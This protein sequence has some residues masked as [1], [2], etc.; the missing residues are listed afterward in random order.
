MTSHIKAIIFDF[1][2]VLVEWEPRHIFRNY[3]P[4]NAAIEAFLQEI[5]FKQW[6]VEQDKGRSFTEGIELL[7]QKFPQHTGIF[8]AFQERW[9]ESIV[10]EIEGTVQLL[11]ELKAKGHPVYGLSN[12]SAE[13]FPIARARYAFFELFDDMVISGEVKLVKPEPAI[14]E[15]CLQ[16]IGRPAHECLFID[17]SE[18]NIIAATKL[19]FD[20]VHFKSPQQLKEELHKRELL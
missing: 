14:F 18:P 1:G 3:F 20:C 19:G 16:K 13:T 15:Y 8:H 7:S 12:W 4:D 6:N 10:G 9:G 11:H 5:D 2:A 17:D